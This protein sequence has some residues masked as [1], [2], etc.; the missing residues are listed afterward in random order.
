[1]ALLATPVF[2]EEDEANRQLAI[3]L[4][5]RPEGTNKAE[6]ELLK[7]I[8]QAR[9][10]FMNVMVSRIHISL[11]ALHEQKDYMPTVKGRL[12]GFETMLIKL[13]KYA[14]PIPDDDGLDGEKKARIIL[15]KWHAEQEGQVLR[16]SAVHCSR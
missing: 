12:A 1:M 3:S 5:K 6:D 11:R 9:P 4:E 8:A 13:M 10:W 7:R 14:E 16:T 15:D 2:T